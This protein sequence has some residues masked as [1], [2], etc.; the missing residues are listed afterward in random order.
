M[1]NNS[2]D[3]PS[4]IASPEST[5]D[6]TIGPLHSWQVF[7]ATGFGVGM[8]SPVGPGTV[9]ALLGIPL[10]LFLSLIH[11][12]GV[13]PAEFFQA[14]AIAALVLV[15]IPICSAAQQA[16]GKKDPSEVVWDEIVTVPI[17]FFLVSSP[18]LMNPLVLLVGFGLHR[19]FDVTKP[20]PCR[21]LE[22]LPAG[23]GIMLDDVAAGFYGFIVMHLWLFSGIGTT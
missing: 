1:T 11:D 21:Q 3:E 10:T 15:G 8:L 18:L 22:R 23:T 14:V 19:L 9:G 17:V 7:L 12:V 6:R 20:P 13:V 4:S 16:L 5:A 2:R